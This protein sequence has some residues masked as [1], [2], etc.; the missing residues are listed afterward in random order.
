[1][2]GVGTKPW[3]SHE[4]EAALIGK[5]ADAAISARP[6]KLRWPSAKPR[7]TMHSKW[8]WPSAAWYARS[9]LQ[10]HRCNR[11]RIKWRRKH[12]PHA[13]GIIGAAVPRIDGPL[14]TTGTA[15]YAVDHDFPGLV[16]AVAVQSTIGKGRIRS[17]DASAAEKM[18]GVLLVLH[19][20]NL[21]NVYRTFP[22]RGR[23]QHEPRRGPLLKTTRST[24]GVSM[25]RWSWPKR[26]SRPLPG[27]TRC[28]WST[29]LEL[30]D[31]RTEPR[32]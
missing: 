31:V 10:L 12:F 3:R 6:L 4:A 29:K 2:G 5:P 9:N 13:G 17:L 18:P 27:P 19:H 16:H 1:M 32:R 21:E 22:H 28:A 20:G 26:W 23:R 14:K 8:N 30:P 24:T 7:K 15:R 25:S 11:R